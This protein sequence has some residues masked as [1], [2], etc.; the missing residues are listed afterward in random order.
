MSYFGTNNA[1]RFFIN[2]RWQTDSN[3]D[4]RYVFWN[5]S[6]LRTDVYYFT[7]SACNQ[8]NMSLCVNKTIDIPVDIFEYQVNI[9]T[10]ETLIR[11]SPYPTYTKRA[12]LGQTDS[13]GIIAVDWEANRFPDGK[14]NI[15]IN[16]TQ[17]EDC[18]DIYAFVNNTPASAVLL[19][20]NT[21]I[22]IFNTTDSDPDYIWLWA[23]KAA[24]GTTTTTFS[25]DVDVF[26]RGP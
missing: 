15:S 12:A 3:N 26:F 25:L 23:T 10:G 16:H 9:S 4:T 24:C 11:F 13:Q 8:F 6:N 22:M 20:N 18:M 5:T 2:L 14:V 21:Y 19:A 17:V 1:S 7:L